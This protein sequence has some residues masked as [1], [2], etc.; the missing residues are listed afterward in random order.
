MIIWVKSFI[1]GKCLLT[2]YAMNTRWYA[3]RKQ[4]T[5]RNS[6]SSWQLWRLWRKSSAVG[7][8]SC[9]RL[10]TAW[11]IRGINAFQDLYSRMSVCL[12]VKQAASKIEEWIRVEIKQKLWSPVSPQTLMYICT[13]L[14][15][16]DQQLSIKLQY[17]SQLSNPPRNCSTNASFTDMEFYTNCIYRNLMAF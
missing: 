16:F 3:L 15:R 7:L 4:H 10:W 9:W 12:S 8:C 5:Q 1:D 2:C 11:I 13:K 17:Y 14:H 6:R